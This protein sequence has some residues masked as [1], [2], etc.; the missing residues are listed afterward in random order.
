MRLDNRAKGS[1]IMG[2][3]YFKR[4][5]GRFLAAL[6]FIRFLY[7]EIVI[8]ER[9]RMVG[10]CGCRLD[11]KLAYLRRLE[12]DDVMPA[13]RD[14]V[15]D[16]AEEA[17][18]FTLA[19]ELLDYVSPPAMKLGKSEEVIGLLEY[20]YSHSI[21]VKEKYGKDWRSSGRSSR[22]WWGGHGN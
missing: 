16:L 3:D 8:S 17:V 1:S 15:R 22:N 21:R 2:I 4:A 10:C 9:L 5:A 20:A 14:V 7:T 11:M 12:G 19:V 13:V 18:P 6:A